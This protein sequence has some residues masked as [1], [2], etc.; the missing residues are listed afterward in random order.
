MAGS[1]P[2]LSHVFNI[3]RHFKMFDYKNNKI[4]K[5]EIVKGA[6]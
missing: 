5:C 6:T 2:G 4:G 1:V 3:I